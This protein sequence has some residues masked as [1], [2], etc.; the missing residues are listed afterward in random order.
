MQESSSLAQDMNAS[1]SSISSGHE[2]KSFLHK[3]RTQM[4]ESPPLAEDTNA[5]VSNIIADAED[6]PAVSPILQ[7]RQQP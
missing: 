1:V 2:C 5:R 6:M 4:Q 7:T 3:L